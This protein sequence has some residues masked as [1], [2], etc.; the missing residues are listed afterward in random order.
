[1]SYIR[2]KVKGKKEVKKNMPDYRKLN[3]TNFIVIYNYLDDYYSLFIIK[4]IQNHK[5]R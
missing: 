5:K 2:I 4:T 3:K 1:M